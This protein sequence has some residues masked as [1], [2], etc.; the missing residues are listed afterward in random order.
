[1]ITIGWTMREPPLVV[2]GIVVQGTAASTYAAL[3]AERI[4]SLQDLRVV[5][6]DGYLVALSDV[7]ALPWIESA[8]W[9]GKDDDLLCPTHLAPDLPSSLV[10]RAVS[11]GQR[12]CGIVVAT[13]D[14]VIVA[15]MPA[16]A[17]SA[18]MLRS[19]EP[20]VGGALR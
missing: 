7:G 12:S 6:G 16:R 2:A 1:M 4:G 17:P 10:A 8:T 13:P 5:A 18:E 11:R 20:S 15:S 19:V 9:L 14:V 3:L